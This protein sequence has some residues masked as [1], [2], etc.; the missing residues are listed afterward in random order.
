MKETLM[1]G[2]TEHE[3]GMLQHVALGCRG[4]EVASSGRRDREIEL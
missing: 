3:V 4:A 2:D 1:Q